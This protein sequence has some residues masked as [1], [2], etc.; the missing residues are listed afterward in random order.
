MSHF[1]GIPRAAMAWT[2]RSSS[3][4]AVRATLWASG[5]AVCFGAVAGAREP[6]TATAETS[7]SAVQAR[8]VARTATSD[9]AGTAAV[10]PKPSRYHPDRFA[11]RAG[12]YYQLN[13]GVDSI[14]VK[15]VE[16]GELVRF[17]YRVLDP[18]KAS[19]LNDKQKAASLIDPRAGVS[20]VVPTMEKV[21]QLRQTSSPEAGRSYWMTFSNKGRRVGRGDRVDVVIGTFSARNLVVD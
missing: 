18:A 5:L 10:R 16:S 15:L 20:L 11:G 4:G 17:S 9:K 3:R 21:G 13:F 14:G 2:L 8:T 1:S 7:P 19:V 12:K 6:A